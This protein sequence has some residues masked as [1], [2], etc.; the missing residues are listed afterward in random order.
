[1]K[2]LIYILISITIEAYSKHCGT[3]GE[4]FAILEHDLIETMHLKLHNLQQT[5]QL[6]QH[7]LN[8]KQQII[9]LIERPVAGFKVIK[10][11]TPRVFLYDPSMQITEDLTDHNGKIFAIKGARINPLKRMS[12]TKSLLF[13]DGDDPLQVHWSLTA[14]PANSKIILING[15][16]LKLS[17][18]HDRKFYF[19]QSGLVKKFGILQVPA[20]VAQQNDMLQVEEILL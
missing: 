8:V 15:A 5:G 10:T 18:I 17:R 12:L 7:Q 4:T 6:Q 19:D 9:N 3:F 20:R 14:N 13:I 16:P 1:M 11:K 2:N